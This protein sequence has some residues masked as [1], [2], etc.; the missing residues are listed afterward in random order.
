M[1]NLAFREVAAKKRE[2]TETQGIISE[3]EKFILIFFLFFFKAL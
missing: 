3:L 2:F 1:E